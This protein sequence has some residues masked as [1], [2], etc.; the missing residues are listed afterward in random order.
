MKNLSKNFTYKEFT[1][2]ATAVMKDLDNTPTEE[3][4]QNGILLCENILEKIRAKFGKVIISSFYRGFRLNKAVGGSSTSQ[5][6]YGQAADFVVP[7][8]SLRIVMDWIIKESGLLWDQVIFEDLQKDG[9][10]IWIHISYDKK[11]ARRQALTMKKI[12]GKA[13]YIHYK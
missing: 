12:N 7:G 1:Y 4:L 13:T 8:V 10:A 3:H 2:S 11:R 9:S 6:C 5:H